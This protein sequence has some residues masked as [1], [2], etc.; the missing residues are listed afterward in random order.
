MSRGPCAIAWHF[1]M[2]KAESGN[3]I[4]GKCPKAARPKTAQKSG[5][6]EDRERRGGEKRVGKQMS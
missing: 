4:E 1:H 2:G 6:R 5:R 3:R